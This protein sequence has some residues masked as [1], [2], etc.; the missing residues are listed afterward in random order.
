M[1][2]K[3]WTSGSVVQTFNTTSGSNSLTVGNTANVKQG[4]N[5]TGAGIPAGTV[6]GTIISGSSLIMINGSTGAAVLAT[7]T[8]TGVSVT[9]DGGYLPDSART[10]ATDLVVDVTALTPVSVFEGS[11]STLKIKPAYLPN[12]VFDSL[13][14]FNFGTGALSQEFSEADKN[15][16]AMNRSSLGYYWIVNA[17]DGQTLS[18]PSGAAIFVQWYADNNSAVSGSSN[19]T[20]TGGTNTSNLAVGMIIKGTGIPLNTTIVSITSPTVIVMSASATQN[21]TGIL[22][23]GYMVSTRIIPGEERN[24]SFEPTSVTV[25]RGDWYIITK[26]VGVGSV[27]SPYVVSFATVNNTYEIMSGATGSVAGAP[28]LVPGPLVANTAQ[29]LRGDATWATPT[30]TNTTYS[31]STVDDGT[32]PYAEVIRLTAGG[33]GSGTDD[34]KIAVGATALRTFAGLTT[35]GSPTIASVT[36]T[37]G[38]LVGQLVTGP[39][40]PVNALITGITLNTSVTLSLNA[41]VTGGGPYTASTFG[42]TIEQASDVITVRHADTSEAS[43]LGVSARRYVTGLTFDT[44]GHV[45]GYSTATETVVD[46]NTATAVDNILDGS[47]SGTAITY[48]PYTN[49]SAGKLSS[50]STLASDDTDLAYSGYFYANRL[51]EGANRVY[52]EANTFTLITAD[53]NDENNETTATNGNLRLNL[54]VDNTVLDFIR[55]NGTGATTVAANNDGIITINSTNTTYTAGNGISLSGTTFSVAGGVGLTQ[56]A[57]GLKMTQPFISSATVPAATYQVTNNLWFDIA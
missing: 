28:G 48:K 57:S 11:G 13:Y 21:G 37:A 8:A 44:F 25:E 1:I 47:N 18:A 34:V 10:N 53:A 5:I 27:A 38:L 33:S 22:E 6:V 46:T 26:I 45:T 41:T 51:Y 30:D 32:N 7:T 39:G 29:F 31:V 49:A 2:I 50:T 4:A 56:E 40:I 55:I 35:S 12:S 43:N 17:T 24:N 36:D 3:R 14:F 16:R 23:F 52:T 54:V 42:L 20:L 15:A 9:F 19:M